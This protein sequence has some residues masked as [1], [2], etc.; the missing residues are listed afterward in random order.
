MAKLK[1]KLIKFTEIKTPQDK[2]SGANKTKPM[3]TV[4]NLSKKYHFDKF[5]YWQG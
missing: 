2:S 4:A 5:I 3:K 1:G